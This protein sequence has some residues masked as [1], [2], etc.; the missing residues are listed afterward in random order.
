M[1][2]IVTIAGGVEPAESSTIA[3]S[4]KGATLLEAHVKTQD[5]YDTDMFS[6][7]AVAAW[8]AA[9]RTRQT[10]QFPH[11]PCQRRHLILDAPAAPALEWIKMYMFP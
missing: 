7:L 5:H 2:T 10:F 3:G 8:L 4:A 1:Q 9:K 6:N 11:V